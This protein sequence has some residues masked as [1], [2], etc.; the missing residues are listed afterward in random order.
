MKITAQ[1]LCGDS[2][3]VLRDFPDA[4]VDACVTDAPYGISIKGKAWDHDVP[5]SPLWREV[6]RV[7]KPGAHLISFF[8]ARTYHRGTVEIEDAGFEIRN[9][10]NWLYSSGVP[11]GQDVG[12]EIAKARCLAEEVDFEWNDW[13]EATRAHWAGEW[14]DWHTEP[15]AALEPACLARKPL[16]E[17][18]VVQ[19]V[20]LTGTGALNVGAVRIGNEER[21]MMRRVGERDTDEK[22]VYGTGFRAMVKIGTTTLGKFPA[23]VYH[24]GSEV[25][26]DRFPAEEDTLPGIS[27]DDFAGVSGP[28]QTGIE[29]SAARFFYN[30]KASQAER[31]ECPHPTIKPVALMRDLVRMVA[32]KGGVVLDPFSGS[33]TTGVACLKEGMVPLL[34]ERDPE[35][36]AWIQN[37]VFPKRPLDEF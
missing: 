18:T 4:C 17:S 1:A 22:K 23:N 11:K 25:V 8:G 20:G 5:K 16:S 9:M 12:R 35:Y 7:L 21:A 36:H 33:G 31:E 10:V 30:S 37:R 6:F 29:K 15:K 28:D 14:Y 32:P 26:V 19:Q 13:D 2:M 34:I 27:L 24:D 3:E